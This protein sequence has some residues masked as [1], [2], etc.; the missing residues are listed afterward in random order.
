MLK[1][2]NRLSIQRT[3]GFLKRYLPWP[4]VPLLQDF[5]VVWMYYAAPFGLLSVLLILR[6]DRPLDDYSGRWMFQMPAKKD[7]LS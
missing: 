6:Q 7:E 3:R 4:K 5:S 2:C 1:H